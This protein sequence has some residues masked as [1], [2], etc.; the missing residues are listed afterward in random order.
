MCQCLDGFMGD[1]YSCV[2]N[3]PLPPGVVAYGPPLVG[4][5]VRP[6]EHKTCI[7]QT[8]CHALAHCVLDESS[9]EGSYFCKCLPGHRGDGVTQCLRQGI[10]FPRPF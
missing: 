5:G 8:E 9:P 3:S 1:G 4:T 2:S 7:D 6:V 10:H